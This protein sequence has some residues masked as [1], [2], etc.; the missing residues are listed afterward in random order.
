MKNQSSSC[1]ETSSPYINR[2]RSAIAEFRLLIDSVPTL[3]FTLFVIA[4][5]SMNLMANKSIT[6]PFDWLAV[7]CGLVVSWFVF[8]VLD[9][10]TKHFGP[11]AA[12][13]LSIFATVLNLLLCMVFFIVS[14]IPGTWGES[15]VS[16]SET[17][18]NTALD[19]TFGGTW[20]IILGSATAF[21]ISAFINN[22]LNFFVG[23]AFR[24]NP[25]GMTAFLCRSYVSTALAQ[26][27][28]NFVFSF[29][30]SRV[31]F[32]W[33]LTQ[34]ITCSLLGM[35]VELLYSVIFSLLGYRICEK[36]R[37]NKVGKEYLCQV[38]PAAQ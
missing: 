9:I 32:G 7:D 15:Y 31:F 17:I 6:V 21:I 25:D 30:V 37:K 5:F 19:N 27:A 13:Q 1:M 11:K 20:Y 8:L 10:L 38:N 23:K 12:T 34:C 33:T 29:L 4:I 16:G 18:I 28:D 14:I 22:F 26:F 3:I 35:L 2:L 36:W 24:K